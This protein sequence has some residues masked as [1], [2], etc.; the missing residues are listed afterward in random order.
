MG[1]FTKIL[2]NINLISD[3]P[4]LTI[5]GTQRRQ[6]ILGSFISL[7]IIG[8]IGT[9]T[10][11]FLKKEMDES[12]PAINFKVEEV[13]TFPKINLYDINFNLA[14]F[15][16]YTVAGGTIL[17]DTR[18]YFTMMAYAMHRVFTK[19]DDG[20][21][22]DMEM[23]I[24]PMKPIRCS[25]ADQSQFQYLLDNPDIS[26]TVLLKSWCFSIEEENKE[27]YFV[28]GQELEKEM[29]SIQLQILPCSLPNPAD[30]EP[31]SVLQ[32]FG[33]NAF[34]P[35]P[36]LDLNK[37]NTGFKYVVDRPMSFYPMVDRTQTL[38]VSLK[39]MELRDEANIFKDSEL[40]LEYVEVMDRDK[41]TGPRNPGSVYCPP[42]MV[43][44]PFACPPYITY[45]IL[46]SGRKEIITRKYGSFMEGLSEAGGFAEIIF[47][48]TGLIFWIVKGNFFVRHLTSK[49]FG[50]EENKKKELDKY[51]DLVEDNFDVLKLMK[52][53]NGLRVLNRIYFKKHH[54]T[55][56]PELLLRIKEEEEGEK[57]HHNKDNQIHHKEPKDA[58]DLP[59]TRDRHG[60]PSGMTV[61]HRSKIDKDEAL[62]KIRSGITDNEIQ[63]R[64]NELFKIYLCE[65]GDQPL[66]NKRKINDDRH[67]NF[68]VV[69]PLGKLKKHLSSKKKLVLGKNKE[70]FGF[71]GEMRGKAGTSKFGSFRVFNNSSKKKRGNGSH[72]G[73]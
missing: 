71:H 14:F 62:T 24:F 17:N 44:N 50:I 25:E 4:E 73:A 67:E 57:N 69:R 19:N 34:N 37:K 45:K 22:V 53:I 40:N 51:S 33:F 10:I 35:K 6:S 2:N 28:K 12:S 36:Q 27:K 26:D 60:N 11:I 21:V 13:S 52:E 31:S 55:L 18:P 32:Q 3:Q 1:R 49:I 39:R 23:E 63:K 20:I 38:S 68:Q 64:I 29:V 61:T 48:F 70:K 46:S 30:C 54:L 65:P 58:Y 56:L 8:L 47:F 5:D 59:V 41:I 7:L 43:G 66:K 15:P 72:R 16:V 42:E 9:I